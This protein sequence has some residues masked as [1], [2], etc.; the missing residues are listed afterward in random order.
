[1]AESHTQRKIR[2][3]LAFRG[4]WTERINSGTVRLSGGGTVKLADPGTPDL[5]VLRP[6]GFLE[7]KEPGKKLRKTQ[8]AWHAKAR[9]HGIR[10]E[11]VYTWEDAV[12][13]VAR[14]GLQDRRSSSAGTTAV[15]G[16]QAPGVSC[17]VP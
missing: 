16:P 5:L 6:Y 9:K 12:A 10:V 15:S 14:W 8:V 2:N 7:V 11:V 3:A 13:V 1:M 17:L 4:I